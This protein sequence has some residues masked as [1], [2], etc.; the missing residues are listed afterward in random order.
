MKMH[1]IRI[2]YVLLL[3]WGGTGLLAQAGLELGPRE[4]LTHRIR[5]IET[6]TYYVS[7]AGEVRMSARET[8]RYDLRG[9]LVAKQV[10]DVA[11]DGSYTLEMDFD[12]SDHSTF[13]QLRSSRGSSSVRWQLTYDDEQRLIAEQDDALGLLRRY[14]Y[15]AAG[16]I[17]AILTS[18]DAESDPFSVERFSYDAAGR[19]RVHQHR[20]ELMVETTRIRYDMAGRRTQVC[21]TSTYRVPGER[22][23]YLCQRFTYDEEGRLRYLDTHDRSGARLRRIVHTYDAEGQL[24][25][26]ACGPHRLRYLRDAADRIIEQQRYL[27]ERLIARQR[28]RYQLWETV[29]LAGS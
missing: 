12:W 25:E 22:D 2:C 18:Y 8:Y 9:N 4:V 16:R 6:T 20:S 19:M 3:C 29:P 26:R 10:F 11:G 21:H 14:R 23:K 13:R 17:S 28:Y 5:G 15:D 7:E 27:G 1:V 24:I